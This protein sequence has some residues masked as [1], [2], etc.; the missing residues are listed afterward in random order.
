MERS[1]HLSVRIT[2]EQAME[3]KYLMSKFDREMAWVIRAALQRMYEQ[4]R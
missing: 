2:E 4:E 3:V 1:V